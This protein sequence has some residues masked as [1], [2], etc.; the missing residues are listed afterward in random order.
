[1]ARTIRRAPD[2]TTTCPT[3]PGSSGATSEHVRVVAHT[4]GV[5][6]DLT[7]L[8]AIVV[9]ALHAPS[10]TYGG[11]RHSRQR[12]GGMAW[13][14][15]AA[16]MQLKAELDQIRTAGIDLDVLDLLRDLFLDDNTACLA[17][18]AGLSRDETYALTNPDGDP[19]YEP[20]WDTLR[21]QCALRDHHE[22]ATEEAH[23]QY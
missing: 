1:M 16:T 22:L 5:N 8:R 18:G 21:F 13:S 2:T 4:R 11:A 15:M 7:T 23:P 14:D 17:L 6:D 20:D 12:A 10:I 3:P 9:K 19:N